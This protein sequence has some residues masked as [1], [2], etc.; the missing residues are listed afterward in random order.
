[1]SFLDQI[2]SGKKAAPRRVLLYGTHG[3]GKSTFGSMAPAP[4]FLPTE[5]GLGE[6]DCDSFPLCLSFPEAINMMAELYGLDHNYKTLV[7]DSLDWLERLIWAD[8]CEKKFVKSIDEIGY[9]KGYAFASDQWRRFL[10]GC[11][12]LRSAKN[13]TIIFIA[14]SKIEKYEEPGAESYDRYKPKLHK[15]ASGL[16]QEWFDEVLFTTYKVATRSIDEGFE[17]KRTIPIGNGERVIYTTERPAHV[18]KNRLALPVE[19]PLDYRV[20]ESFL[21]EEKEDG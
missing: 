1:M 18:A 15:L 9:G 19:I 10:D 21:A 6:I 2:E 7:V 14:H 12:A 16:I 11:T 4:I 5:D 13:M 8:V 3:I 20:F 17:K